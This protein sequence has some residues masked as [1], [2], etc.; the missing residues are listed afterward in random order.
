MGPP[1]TIQLHT[2]SPFH[3]FFRPETTVST[4]YH[5]LAG[6]ATHRKPLAA[7]N[8]EGLLN[9][10]YHSHSLQETVS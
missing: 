5:V 2:E 9:P 4:V 7:E 8:G 3:C 10:I 1:Y 6:I